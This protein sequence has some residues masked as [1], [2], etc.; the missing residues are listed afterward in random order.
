[1]KKALLVID[2]QNDMLWENRNKRFAYDTE[3]LLSR[4][5]KAIHL[6]KKNGD[7][8][9]YIAHIVS[10]NWFSKKIFGYCIRNTE[11]SRLH[12]NLSIESQNYFEKSRADAFTSKKLTDFIR[13]Q[14]FETVA[15]CGIDEGGCVSA[16]AKGAIKLGL[17]VEMLTNCIDTICPKSKID[18]LRDELKAKGVKYI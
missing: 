17:S 6:Y 9:I 2:L 15:I 13:K 12:K 4:V 16:T 3:P 8:V 10:N 14:N 18:K 11:G 5:N 1:M 7:T